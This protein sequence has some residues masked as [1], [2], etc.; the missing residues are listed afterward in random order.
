MRTFQDIISK[1]QQNQPV[2]IAVAAA[3][4]I[5]V[6]QAVSAAAKLNVASFHL[7]GDEKKIRD[8]VRKINLSLDTVEISNEAD[9][10]SACN[11]AVESVSRG[12]SQILMKGLVPTATLLR[13]VL[14]KEIGLRGERILS[15]VALFEIEGYDRLIFVTDAA[16]NITPT[17]EQKAEIVQNAVD[18]VHSIGI[19]Q[20]KVAA[21]AAIETINPKMQATLDAALLSKM[22]ERG[23][24]KGAVIDGPLALDNAISLEAAAH[25][26]IES[27]VAGN[28][29][30]LLVPS[31]EVGNV[32]YKSIV[33]FAKAKVGAVLAGAKA[34]VVLTSRADSHETK[35]NSIMLAVL[36][37]QKD[38]PPQQAKL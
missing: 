8:Y 16:M 18:L 34:P 9:P 2:T 19:K 23:Q 30:I 20:P 21:L 33:Y 11:K 27:K 10:V 3:D 15:H 28:A 5:E 35:L 7:L 6:L 14:D 26:G 17:L 38:T 36:S 29:D 24:I 1:I 13:A 4:D 25:K 12:N 31:I 37:A 32:L 22:A